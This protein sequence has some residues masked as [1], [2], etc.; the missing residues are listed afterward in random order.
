MQARCEIALTRPD[1]MVLSTAGPPRGRPASPLWRRRSAPSVV[2]LELGG[3]QHGADKSALY[4][5]FLSVG[6]ITRLAAVELGIGRVDGAP[7]HG[8]VC[9]RYKVGDE[10]LDL[11]FLRFL[12]ILDLHAACDEDSVLQYT[13]DVDLAAVG[14]IGGG[15][16]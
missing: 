7:R 15:P 1:G 16:V 10:A 13:L 12:R 11:D 8:E 4:L 9:N 3:F 5:D 14:E 6:K 2:E